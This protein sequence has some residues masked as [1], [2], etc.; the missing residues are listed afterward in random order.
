MGGCVSL[1]MNENAAKPP[2]RI[3]V[4]S[5]K[6]GSNEQQKISRL[7]WKKKER[8]SSYIVIQ[9]YETV[10]VNDKSSCNAPLHFT[11]DTQ[12]NAILKRLWVTKPV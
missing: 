1:E 7:H 4:A 10:A 8:V 5:R 9:E 12:H 2:K 11:G 3:T 6:I